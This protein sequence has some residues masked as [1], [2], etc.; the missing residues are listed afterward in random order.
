MIILIATMKAKQG[1]EAELE[2]ALKSVIPKVGLEKGTLQYILHRSQD[3]SRTF[4]FYEKYADKEA[5]DFHGST[6]YLKELFNTIPNLLSEKPS[7]A[8]YEEIASAK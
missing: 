3:D 5:L 8:L 1:K 6:P 7:I 4:L 2:T